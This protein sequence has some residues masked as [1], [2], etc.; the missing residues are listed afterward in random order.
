MRRFVA[1]DAEPVAAWAGRAG[2]STWTPEALGGAASVPAAQ[3]VV[4]ERGG[5]PVAA[6]L[7]TVAADEASLDLLVVDPALRRRGWG[8]RVLARWLDRAAAAGAAVARLEV[9]RRNA[10]AQALYEAAG[11]RSAGSRPRYYADGDDALFLVKALPEAGDL[12]ALVVAGGEGRR[13]GRRAKPLLR[14]ADGLTLLEAL[15]ESLAPF[16]PRVWLCAPAPVAAA[17]RVAEPAVASLSLVVDQGR[18]PG[19]AVQRAA[20]RSTAERVL[21]TVADAPRP[22]RDLWRALLEALGQADAAVVLADGRLQVGAVVA[23]RRALPIEPTPSLQGLLRG[24]D[25][26]FVPERALSTSAR[27]ALRDVDEPA[28]LKDPI[29]APES[30]RPEDSG[31]AA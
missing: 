7:G 14:R 18:G 16:T 31:D 9:A 12:E 10:P 30:A 4:L 8:R 5:R 25:V 22:H 15:L 20:A 27:S 23:R 19:L 1:E 2:L 6:A 21:W 29:L 3:T 11:F 17:L 13:L 26:R 28:D 24:L